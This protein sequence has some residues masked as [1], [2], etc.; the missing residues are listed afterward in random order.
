MQQF[1]RF[2]VI[3]TLTNRGAPL[4]YSKARQLK[5]AAILI[6]ALLIPAQAFSQSAELDMTSAPSTQGWTTV[7]TPSSVSSWAPGILTLSAPVS[8]LISHEAPPALWSVAAADPSGYEVEVEMKVVAYTETS[9]PVVEVYF[10][11]GVH[12]CIFLI[13]SDHITFYGPWSGTTSYAMDTS[14]GFHQYLLTGTGTHVDVLVDGVLR[15]SGDNLTGNTTSPRLLF[16]K[17][18][19]PNDT[20]TEWKYVAFRALGAV[21]NDTATW[22]GVKALFR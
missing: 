21:A 13:F 20:V 3:L 11:N 14:D 19:F 12:Y 10:F 16:G 8:G 1:G 18:F 4:L 22:G 7:G 2:F 17:A 6:A 9:E 5:H 15:L